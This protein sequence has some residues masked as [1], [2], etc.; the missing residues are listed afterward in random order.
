MKFHVPVS[1]F[2]RWRDAFLRHERKG[3]QDKWSYNGRFWSRILSEELFSQ[4]IEFACK[5][6]WMDNVGACQLSV[7]LSNPG[8]ILVSGDLWA[9]R[10]N[11]GLLAPIPPRLGICRLMARLSVIIGFANSELS[12]GFGSYPLRRRRKLNNSPPVIRANAST[13]PLAI[14]PQVMYTLAGRDRFVASGQTQ[15]KDHYPTQ[16]TKYEDRSNMDFCK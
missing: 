16:G 14:H 15:R 7:V 6:I 12:G 2:Y 5:A 10:G 9:I 11:P 3:P 1:A 4:V 8:S 13:I